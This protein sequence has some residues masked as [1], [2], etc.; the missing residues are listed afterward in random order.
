MPICP[1]CETQGEELFS[2]CPTGDGYFLVDDDEY[3]SHTSDPWLGLRLGDR[4]IIAS[5]LGQGSMGYVYKAHQIQVERMVAVKIFQTN[6]VVLTDEDGPVSQDRFVQEARV[7]AKLSHPNCVTLYDFG[8]DHEG[9]FLY[10]AMEL[11]GG[12]SLR[13]AVRRGIKI[14]AVVEVVRQVLMALR[15]AHALEIV[16]RD[17]KPENIILSYRQTSNEQIVKVLDFGIAKLLRKDPGK[18]TAAGLLFGT[19]AYMSP[20]QCRGETNVSPASDIYSLGCML[21]EM[22]AGHLPFDSDL[23]QEMVRQHQFEPMP[24]LVPRKG[25]ELPKGVEQFVQKCM[26]KEP[27]NRYPNAKVALA[28][29]EEIVGGE[30]RTGQLASGLETLGDDVTS[31]RVAVP[32]NRITGA[33][34]DPTGEFSAEKVREI[35]SSMPAQ[36]R[37]RSAQPDALSVSDTVRGTKNTRNASAG[38]DQGSLFSARSGLVVLAVLA[39]GV[40]FVLFAAF[41]YILVTG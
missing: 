38:S 9:D 28:A 22:I 3:F 40:F 30:A 34:L 11:V 18:R 36:D 14:E 29:F 26:E 39:V 21:F 4:F 20:E 27:E 10:I 16:H 2:P 24:K 15:E 25:S 23:P 31:R 1:N 35:A 17:L 8:Y 12:I 7:L 13:R 19:P 41:V 32:K 6:K 5:I 33:K 37:K